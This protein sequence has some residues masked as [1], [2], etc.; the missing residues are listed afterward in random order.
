M[1]IDELEKISNGVGRSV[2]KIMFR[3]LPGST[4]E[5]RETG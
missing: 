2:I 5:T 1:T 4:E 3:K